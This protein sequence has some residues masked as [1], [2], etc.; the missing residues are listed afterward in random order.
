MP[1]VYEALS[2]YW[3]VFTSSYIVVPSVPGIFRKL[4]L[5]DSLIDEFK[6]DSNRSLK[7]ILVE[8]KRKTPQL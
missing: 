4:G 6:N 7:T 8:I 5:L 1:R 3:P 2:S